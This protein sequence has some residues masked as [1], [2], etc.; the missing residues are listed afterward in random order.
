MDP[1]NADR[2]A[3]WRE[4]HT[5]PVRPD[6]NAARNGKRNADLTANVTAHSRA[7]GTT[8]TETERIKVPTPLGAVGDDQP[9]RAP[10]KTNGQSGDVLSQLLTPE[11]LA[12]WQTFGHEWDDFKR[13]WIGHGFR[14]PPAGDADDDPDETNPSQRAMLH[15]VLVDRPE[16]IV[17]WIRECK[18]R[19]AHEV[20]AHVLT[21]WH[22]LRGAVRDEAKPPLKAPA[23]WFERPTP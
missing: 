17:E 1:S 4:S 5:L 12:A 23:D 14:L 19:T 15:S 13:A 8:E 2:Q 10:D 20:I 6:S 16:S 18:T 11:Q 22:E 21:R 9:P 7:R 3:I